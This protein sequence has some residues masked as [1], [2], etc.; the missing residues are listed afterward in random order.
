MVAV[1]IVAFTL[2]IGTLALIINVYRTINQYFN[3]RENVIE[4]LLKKNICI[5]YAIN[6]KNAKYD[7]GNI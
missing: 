6:R 5:V 4:V 7:K 2:L 1:T 3:G